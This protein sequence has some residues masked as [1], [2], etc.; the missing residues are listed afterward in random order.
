MKMSQ[1]GKKAFNYETGQFICHTFASLTA[2]EKSILDEVIEIIQNKQK[3]N[4][5]W[6]WLPITDIGTEDEADLNLHITLLRGHRA[7]YYHQIKPLIEALKSECAN[8]Q[9]VCLCLDEFR[10]FHN[11]ER[12]KQFLCITP[13]N[14]NHISEESRKL[15]LL[16]DRIQQVVDKFAIKLTN[17]D[18]DI[19]TLAHCSLMCR[20]ILDDKNKFDANNFILDLQDLCLSNLNEYPVCVTK[21]NQIRVKVGKRMYD[22]DLS[23]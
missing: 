6:A 13:R 14:T 22:V 23:R 20:E 17:E 8:I 7:I 2:D 18:E 19:D 5:D 21:I 4:L 10:I 9:P 15:S 12:T 11:F 3:E 1:A 16:K